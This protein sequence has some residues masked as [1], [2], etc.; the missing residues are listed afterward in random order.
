MKRTQLKLLT[1]FLAACSLVLVVAGYGQSGD[2]LPTGQISI[3]LITGTAPVNGTN[4]V[5]TLTLSS[6]TAGAYKVTFA[7][8]TAAVSL[9]G[10]ETQSIAATKFQ[11][12]LLALPTIGASGVAI[13]SGT[14][15]TPAILTVT[16]GGNLQ[17]LNV[18]QFATAVTSGTNTLVAAIATPGV[19][20]DG[21]SAKRAALINDIGDAALYQNRST[22]LL[23]PT[24]SKISSE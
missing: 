18:P 13:T 5:Q 24:W 6:T 3:P 20:A 15:S 2:P 17:K 8:S 16:F 21:R 11:T 12:A 1:V 4:A 19:T 22:V 23:S 14:G 7:G 10:T 9:T